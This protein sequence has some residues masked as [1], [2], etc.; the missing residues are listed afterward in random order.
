MVLG[1][2]RPATLSLTILEY[3][4]LFLMVEV[5][6]FIKRC[7]FSF[8]NRRSIVNVEGRG[9]YRYHTSYS[10]LRLS[11]GC[12]RFS[13][14]LFPSRPVD[15]QFCEDKIVGYSGHGSDKGNISFDYGGG[16]QNIS[17][18]YGYLRGGI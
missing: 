6:L 1:H 2:K 10:S 9:G 12:G 17:C 14:V 8:H 16:S 15:E 7:H 4:V 3:I 18:Y 11:G 13:G 5:D